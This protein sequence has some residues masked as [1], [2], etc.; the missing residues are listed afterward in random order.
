MERR[1]LSYTLNAFLFP[2]PEAD[3]LL[4]LTLA[5]PLVLRGL[6]IWNYNKTVDCVGVLQ[7][8][9][10][11]EFASRKAEIAVPLTTWIRSC[12]SFMSFH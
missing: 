2:L 1:I 5:A 9:A 6:R 10:H 12:I 3:H 8:G 4:T 7:D 11:K